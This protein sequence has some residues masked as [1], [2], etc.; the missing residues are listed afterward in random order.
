MFDLG[1]LFLA[2]VRYMLDQKNIKV[3]Y[4]VNN[5]KQVLPLYQEVSKFMEE[6]PDFAKAALGTGDKGKELK[7]FTRTQYK[8][9]KSEMQVRIVETFKDAPSKANLDS[10]C[11]GGSRLKEDQLGSYKCPN[12]QVNK[13][14]DFDMT[15]SPLYDL[16]DRANTLKVKMTGEHKTNVF[17][18]NLF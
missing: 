8:A 2:G 4:A 6:T 5:K 11:P 14:L 7:T 16:C 9:L 3:V 15:I 17:F 10:S 13:A 1:F 12:A 18:Y